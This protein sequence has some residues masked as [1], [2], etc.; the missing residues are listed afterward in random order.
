MVKRF[1][2]RVKGVGMADAREEDGYLIGALLQLPFAALTR[3]VQEGL[4]AAGFA[5]V[6][7]VHTPVFRLLDPAGNRVTELAARAGM[8]K[9]AMGYLVDYLEEHGYLERMA[10]PTDKRAQ[11]VR[12]TARG[13]AVNRE[14]RRLVEQVQAEWAA[15]LGE[16][17]MRQLREILADLVRV[18]GHEYTGSISEVCSRAAAVG[19]VAG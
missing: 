8:S 5:D 13:W 12:R 9:Q 3:R 2:Y 17:R 16:E 1:V 7:P 10:D 19:R 14:A 18:L 15:E 4:A 6:R 11:L